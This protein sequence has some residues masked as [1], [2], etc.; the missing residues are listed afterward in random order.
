MYSLCDIGIT[1][2]APNLGLPSTY[3]YL[4]LY[5]RRKETYL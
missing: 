3:M 1:V 4:R 2:Q 5:L